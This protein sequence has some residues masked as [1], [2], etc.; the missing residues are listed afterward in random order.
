[1]RNHCRTLCQLQNCKTDSKLTKQRTVHVSL[2]ILFLGNRRDHCSDNISNLYARQNDK[3]TFSKDS[4][5][6]GRNYAG[7][8]YV[9]RLVFFLFATFFSRKVTHDP[10]ISKLFLF[11]FEFSFTC[12]LYVFKSEQIIHFTAYLQREKKGMHYFFKIEWQWQWVKTF[13]VSFILFVI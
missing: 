2:F 8:G 5:R 4:K 13:H 6:F 10:R 12:Y 9:L 11:F 7:S 1:M 3:T